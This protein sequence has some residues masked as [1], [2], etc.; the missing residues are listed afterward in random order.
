[1][2]PAQ[3]LHAPLI[4]NSYSQAKADAE[5]KEVEAKLAEMGG[6]AVAAIK[7]AQKEARAEKKDKQQGSATTG[8]ASAGGA[9]AGAAPA[10]GGSGRKRKVGVL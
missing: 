7:E 2:C 4:S 6:D 8:G 3:P 10:A 5:K 1:M 9:A